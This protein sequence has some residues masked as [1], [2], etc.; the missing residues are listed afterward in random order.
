MKRIYSILLTCLIPLGLTVG[1]SDFLDVK[2]T[3]SITSEAL[4]SS[5]SGIQAYL[6][7]LYNEMPIE[8]FAFMPSAS[9]GNYPEKGFNFNIG[10]SNNNGNFEWTNT[11][12]AI[13]SQG[14]NII[15]TGSYRYWDDAYKLNNHINA[16]IGYID[17]LTSV[18]SESKKAL[19]GQAWFARA[20]TYFPCPPLR[21]SPHHHQGRRPQR[22]HH[23]IHPQ[24]QGSRNLGL[25]PRMLRLCHS[26]SRH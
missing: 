21:R 23:H 4:F 19:R 20:Y 18:S 6:A 26:L 1:C 14:D 24:K 10:D 13:G 16:F 15:G 9:N 3:D 2:P 22:F 12:D 11:D 8:D 5:E 17:G 7:T 25:G